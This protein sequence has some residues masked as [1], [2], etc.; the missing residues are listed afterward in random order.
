MLKNTVRIRISNRY[1]YKSV[2]SNEING[3]RAWLD[4]TERKLRFDA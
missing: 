3:L 1:I 2:K 4:A